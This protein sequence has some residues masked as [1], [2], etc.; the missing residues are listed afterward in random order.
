MEEQIQ[1]SVNL[2]IPSRWRRFFAY[3][4]DLVINITIIWLFANII[5]IFV[6][7]TTLWNM[8]I[9]I[10]TLNN[11]NNSANLRQALLRYLIFYQILPL[12][13]FFLLFLR[14]NLYTFKCS[15]LYVDK[16][17]GV[18]FYFNETW[19]CISLNTILVILRYT[20]YI[21]TIICTTINIIEIFFKCPTFID[22]QLWI[23][24]IYKK[25]KKNN[26]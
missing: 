10:R 8:L 17:N 23:K 2:E 4:L 18:G 7:K 20:F 24:R 3:F 6:E 1:N 26:E 13:F 19:S 15:Y 5:L 12:L 25:S 22:K 21:L 16:A 9:W 11:K 14:W